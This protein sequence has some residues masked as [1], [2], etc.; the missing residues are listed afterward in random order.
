MHARIEMVAKFAPLVNAV[1][2]AHKKRRNATML[3]RS[4]A[5]VLLAEGFSSLT[6]TSFMK[7]N[8]DP[9]EPAAR[10][11]GSGEKPWRR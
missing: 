1:V 4:S 5:S 8:P 3:E 9:R 6:F 7:V 2:C 11:S 10:R